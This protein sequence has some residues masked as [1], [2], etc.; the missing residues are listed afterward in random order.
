MNLLVLQHHPAEHPG[1]FRQF[2]QADGH[3]LT[4]VQ[5]D[6]NEPL[7][8]TLN[9]IDGLWVMGGPMDVWQTD[10][11]PWLAAE[12]AFIHQ[13]VVEH[14]LPYFGFCLGHQ[15]L[16]EALGGRVGPAVVPEIGL[17]DV[18]ATQYG[19]DCAL[20]DRLPKTLPCLQWHSAEV[21][22]LP[23]GALCLADSPSCAIEAMQWGKHAYSVQ[24][25]L[26]IEQD[27]VDNWMAIPAYRDALIQALGADAVDGLRHA[28]AENMVQMQ[29]HAECI[30]GNWMGAVG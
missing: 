8:D 29:G 28:C 11:H 27:T 10:S 25:H 16:A 1:I 24:F 5:L 23:A 6:Q 9:G 15:L 20:L 7:P 21:T 26:E 14:Q 22:Q 18:Y 4:T 2:L 17:L 12:K 19:I 13:A 3:T 30:Y